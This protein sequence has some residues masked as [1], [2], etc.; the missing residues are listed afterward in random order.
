M[1]TTTEYD[2]KLADT[3]RSLSLEPVTDEFEPPK[4]S[5]RRLLILG[6]VLAL[7]T[8]TS[9][10]VLALHRP[11]A[12][13][14]IK[15]VLFA[16]P[17]TA[18]NPA[19]SYKDADASSEHAKMQQ[20]AREGAQSAVPT[21]VLVT[22]DVTGS[23]YVV[24]PHFTTV[25]SKYEGRIVGVAVD[26]GDKVEAGQVLV[27]LD[28]A[29]ARLSLEEARAANISAEL[30]LASRQIDLAQARSSLDRVKVLSARDAASKQQ[31]EDACAAWER[32]A[33]NVIA[34]PSGIRPNMAARIR[35]PVIL[36]NPDDHHGDTVK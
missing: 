22:R 17:K 32:A 12:A 29:S 11:D 27:T 3:L 5:S 8:A 16:A 9:F 2:R 1:N 15:T 4:R 19:V 33:S 10:V 31:L 28:D 24:A 36:P 7:V 26:V 13:E 30:V 6:C 34:P 21:S 25:Y 23:G 18:G 14:R 35:I 20:K